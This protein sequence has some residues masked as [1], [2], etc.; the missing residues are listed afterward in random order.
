MVNSG[1]LVERE[2]VF[3]RGSGSLAIWLHQDFVLSL[4][5][6]VR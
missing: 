6:W 4:C 1:T 5:S 2:G 3:D